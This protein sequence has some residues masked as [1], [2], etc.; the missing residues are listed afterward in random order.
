MR[1]DTING[2]DVVH[3]A[4]LNDSNGNP[5]RGW[6]VTIRARGRVT[7]VHFIDEGCEGI[8]P[9]KKA[10]P[11]LNVSSAMFDSEKIS[12]ADYN[13]YRKLPPMQP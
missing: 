6:H 2:A 9:L 13:A 7:S 3:L 10:F 5:R 4:A 12:V 11:D 8:A 1:F